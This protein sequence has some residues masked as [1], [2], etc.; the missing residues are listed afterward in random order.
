MAAAL[1][2]FVAWGGLAQAAPNAVL[3]D[4]GAKGID[5]GEARVP[6]TV[7]GKKKL[8]LD[9]EKYEKVL[10]RPNGT[11]IDAAEPANDSRETAVSLDE[12]VFAAEVGGD[13]AADFIHLPADLE[14][15]GYGTL[16]HVYVWSGDVRLE[17][18]GPDL[19]NYPSTPLAQGKSVWIGLK[20]NADCAVKVVS[21]TGDPARYMIS[22]VATPLGDPDEPNDHWTAG[23]PTHLSW[24]AAHAGRFGGITGGPPP[25]PQPNIDYYDFQLTRPAN[26]SVR[27]TGANLPDGARVRL[28]LFNPQVS[29]SPA[30]ANGA[31]GKCDVTGTAQGAT[32]NVNMTGLDFSSF[33]AGTW[34]VSARVVGSSRDWCGSGQP[35]KCYTQPYSIRITRSH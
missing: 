17:L 13:D 26:L 15:D 10:P 27:L 30:C 14:P 35:P 3:L 29:S 6:A 18:Y 12:G 28:T 2:S 9:T 16:L 7:P 34:R 31:W 21:E 32:L 24:N 5:P 20:K 4:Q 8:Q 1:F 33:P 25:A 19:P 11:A 23:E 22:A